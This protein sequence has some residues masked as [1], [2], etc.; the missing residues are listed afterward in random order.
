MQNKVES[1]T[2]SREKSTKESLDTATKAIAI[3]KKLEDQQGNSKTDE[4]EKKDE[5][6]WRNEG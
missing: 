1:K 4:E 5:E 6:L 2:D 3:E